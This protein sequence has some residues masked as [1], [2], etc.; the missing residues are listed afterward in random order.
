R[1]PSTGNAPSVTRVFRYTRQMLLC[2]VRGCR[3]PLVRDERRLLCQRGHSF[4]I[5]RNGYI[6][7]LQPQDRRSRHPGDATAVVAARR[8][9]HDRGVTAPLLRAI[10]EFAPTTPDDVVL[11]VGCGDGFYLANLC[12]QTGFDAHGVDISIAAMD[13]ASRRYP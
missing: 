11:D 8:R 2:T 4:D 10:A 5:A 3:M 6:N 12:R 7:L 1:T 13:A 9:L